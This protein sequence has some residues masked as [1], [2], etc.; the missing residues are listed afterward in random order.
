[1]SGW[2]TNCGVIYNHTYRDFAVLDPVGPAKGVL[3]S[4]RGH[5]TFECTELFWECESTTQVV[6]NALRFQVDTRNTAVRPE[7][8]TFF[9]FMEKNTTTIVWCRQPPSY[10]NRI[11]TNESRAGCL[12]VHIEIDPTAPAGAEFSPRVVKNW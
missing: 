4:A 2:R 3:L 6:D 9:M 7:N 1:V 11:S 5:A 10:D 12:D 8:A